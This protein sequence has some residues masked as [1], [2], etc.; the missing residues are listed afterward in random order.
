MSVTNGSLMALLQG[1]GPKMNATRHCLVQKPTATTKCVKYE[2]GPYNF[3]MSGEVEN[4]P[5]Y[6]DY[7]HDLT[8]YQK[9]LLKKYGG[10]YTEEALREAILERGSL[11]VLSP[12]E[13]KEQF[14]TAKE[15][16]NQRARERRLERKQ[17]AELAQSFPGSAVAEPEEKR[18]NRRIQRMLGEPITRSGFPNVP[19]KGKG[20]VGGC[21]CCG[22]PIEGSAIIG[23]Y[24]G[25]SGPRTPA[26]MA[27][28]ELLRQ[29]NEMYR[30]AKV[31]QPFLT[32]SQ[33]F[34]QF[35]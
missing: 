19:R 34:S 22:Q 6:L 4:P 18:E 11:P 21:G 15:R 2:K 16:K 7:A 1:G 14:M 35:H 17:E 32:R 13:L 20:L 31:M 25:R 3:D 12:G 9:K 24:D 28:A 33:F 29:R 27:A 26:Q 23:G 8:K 5:V 10:P 30:E